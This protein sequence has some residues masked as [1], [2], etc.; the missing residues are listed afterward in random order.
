[1]RSGFKCGKPDLGTEH[2][3]RAQDKPGS[4]WPLK[5]KS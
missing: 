3:S 2:K 5:P 1:M 4:D